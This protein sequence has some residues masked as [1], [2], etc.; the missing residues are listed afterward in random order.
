MSF[1]FFNLARPREKCEDD[2]PKCN[3]TGLDHGAVGRDT[4]N[5][6]NLWK[7]LSFQEKTKPCLK[8]FKVFSFYN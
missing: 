3:S 1:V 4:G 6:V 8:N 2:K 5:Q 7:L